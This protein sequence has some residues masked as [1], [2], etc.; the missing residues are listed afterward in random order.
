LEIDGDR[1]TRRVMPSSEGMILTCPNPE[2][3]SAPLTEDHK[4]LGRVVGRVSRL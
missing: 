3:P 4:V 1:M 2:Y